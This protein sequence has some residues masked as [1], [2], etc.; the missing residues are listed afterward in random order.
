MS[1]LCLVTVGPTW[2]KNGESC[3]FLPDFQLLLPYIS[4]HHDKNRNICSHTLAHSPPKISAKFAH[5]CPNNL[6]RH[7]ANCT[8]N[9]ENCQF[10]PVFQPLLLHTL[11]HPNKIWIIHSHTLARS[12][13]KISAKLAHRHLSNWPRHW[14]TRAK[15]GE[16]C[17]FLPVFQPLLPHTLSNPNKIW[18]IHSHTLARS[19]PKI[20]AKSAHRGP[21][22][23]PCRRATRAK[24]GENC[25][26]FKNVTNKIFWFFTKF[27]QICNQH[28]KT[29]PM[30]P[31]MSQ[32]I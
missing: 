5:R 15:N 27:W 30:T 12:P 17:Q 32:V 3:Q 10:L 11:S 29:V 19:P 21:S 1:K 20:S 8:K 26:F 4:L 24:N 14:A 18:I 6:L 9:S 13:S 16:N 2:A 28:S 22:N 7:W 25:R 31:N 23:R